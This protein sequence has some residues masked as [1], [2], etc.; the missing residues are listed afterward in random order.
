MNLRNWWKNCVNW[1]ANFCIEA[2]Y[3][4]YN[5]GAISYEEALRNAHSNEWI[6][7][8]DQT[9]KYRQVK[10]LPASA[11]A[12]LQYAA[13]HAQHEDKDH[14]GRQHFHIHAQNDTQALF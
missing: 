9:E 3:D 4:L 8:G 12:H 14:T 11:P 7:L 1:D 2:L 13:E 5:E 6:A 10:R